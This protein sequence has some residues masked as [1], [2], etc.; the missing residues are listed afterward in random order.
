MAVDVMFVNEVSF[1]VSMTTGLNLVTT[2]F[3]PSRTAKQLVAGITWMMDL[4]AC[5]GF[6]VGT[7]LMDNKFE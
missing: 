2:K 3:T 4:Y 7:V 6:Q 1:L 5:R